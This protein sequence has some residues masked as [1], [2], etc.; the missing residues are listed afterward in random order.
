MRKT[1]ELV[2]DFDV[3]GFGGV[4]AVRRSVVLSGKRQASF[5]ALGK[6]K[7]RKDAKYTDLDNIDESGAVTLPDALFLYSLVVAFKPKRIL[8][9]GT[10]FGTTAYIMEKAQRDTGIEPCVHTCDK[11]DVFV[12]NKD[13]AV[14]YYNKMSTSFLKKML[15]PKA[16]FIFIDAR[17][18]RED[19]KLIKKMCTK[20]TVIACH[21]WGQGKGT[22]NIKAMK[23]LKKKL[24][25]PKTQEV[26]GHKINTMISVLL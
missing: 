2:T 10:W 5:G 25:V 6:R 4:E 26:D 13:S 21:D 22:A 20:D 8:E 17:L 7:K 14:R 23:V 1:S 19:P 16:D 11:H 12:R 3:D 24:Y 15:G 18:E 9:I